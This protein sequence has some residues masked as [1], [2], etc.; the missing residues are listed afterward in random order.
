[1]TT[2]LSAWLLEQIAEDEKYARGEALESPPWAW[3]LH[4]LTWC[5]AKRRLVGLHTDEEEHDCP[6]EDGGSVYFNYLKGWA[7]EADNPQVCPTLRLIA[8]PY[9]DRPG[10]REEWKP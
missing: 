7:E 10:Y 2:P 6:T 3:A 9:A 8:L 1:M 5:E 4:A